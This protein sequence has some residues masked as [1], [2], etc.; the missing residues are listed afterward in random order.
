MKIRYED[1]FEYVIHCDPSLIVSDLEFI[2]LSL[3][4]ILEN[5]FQHGFKKVL[6]IW[7]IHIYCSGS[8][9]DWT[10]I[11]KDNGYGISETSLDALHIRIDEFLSNPSDSIASLKL[12]GMGLINTLARLKLR[13]KN[14]FTYDITNNDPNGTTITLKGGN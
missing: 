7:H 9:D 10:I 1:Q 8:I 5:C 12:G 6:P 2:K 3:Q 13:Y 11:I 14:N 4:P